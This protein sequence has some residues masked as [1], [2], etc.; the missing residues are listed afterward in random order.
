MNSVAILAVTV[1]LLAG[2]VLIVRRLTRNQKTVAITAPT[3]IVAVLILLPIILRKLNCSCYT[4]FPSK[5][6]GWPLPFQTY[7]GTV[8]N[9][10]I[11]FSLLY[12]IFDIVFVYIIFALLVFAYSLLVGKK[13]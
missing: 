4:D 12:L 11:N 7:Y 1:L 10:V 13:K 2:I 9:Q 8:S 3:I 5:N 6:L